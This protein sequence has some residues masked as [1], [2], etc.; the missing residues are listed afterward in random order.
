MDISFKCPTCDQELEVDASGAGSSIACPSCATLITVPSP[1]AEPA[2]QPAPPP[3][4]V[5]KHF[6]VPVRDGQPPAEPLIK[7][8]NRPLEIAAKDDEKTVR[9]KTFKR[10]ECVE[11]GK[12]HFD[13]KVSEFLAKVGQP[14]IISI[15]P[16]NYSYVEVGSRAVITDYGVTIVF[17]G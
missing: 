3:P 6:T 16:V 13:E 5:E 15:N 1:P 7:K 9:I 10:T 14:N 11:V 4:K 17:R 2:E 12:D 8:A